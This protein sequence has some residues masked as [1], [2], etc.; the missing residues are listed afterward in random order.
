MPEFACTECYA[1]LVDDNELQQNKVDYIA[2]KIAG[3][4]LI[5]SLYALA[6]WNPK[7]G[8]AQFTL[9]ILFFAICAPLGYDTLCYKWLI[10]EQ[11]LSRF[12][13]LWGYLE[14][15][16]NL[17]GV[18]WSIHL[19]VYACLLTAFYRLSQKTSNPALAFAM[20]ATL[21]GL[22]F[23]FLSIIRQA[24]A[25]ALMIHGC[26]EIQKKLWIRGSMIFTIAVLAHSSCLPWIM[27]FLTYSAFNAGGDRLQRIAIISIGFIFTGAIVFNQETLS[28]LRYVRMFENYVE[29]RNA[30]E[31]GKMLALFWIVIGVGSLFLRNVYMREHVGRGQNIRVAAIVVLYVALFIYLGEAIRFVWYL[32]PLLIF[33]VVGSIRPN[34]NNGNLNYIRLSVTVAISLLAIYPIFMAPEYYWKDQYPFGWYILEE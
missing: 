19:I 23:S 27:V 5:S 34:S 18:W 2:T 26:L 25:T 32:L 33:D 10:E 12:G 4:I 13:L 8:R 24:L 31:S 1:E 7:V 20:L 9:G 15:I 3:A 14:E 30:A 6:M 22:G 16:P 21:P 29:D 28:A 17:T 11:S